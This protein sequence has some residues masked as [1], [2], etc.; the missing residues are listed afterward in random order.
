MLRFLSDF[1][2]YFILKFLQ[3]QTKLQLLLMKQ[4]QLVYYIEEDQAEEKM[5]V[6]FEKKQSDT[7]EHIHYFTIYIL[8]DKLLFKNRRKN[9]FSCKI[10]C[11]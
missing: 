10:F 9:Y 1:S 11:T 5:M 7:H 3:K 6:H 8:I 4:K 2:Y